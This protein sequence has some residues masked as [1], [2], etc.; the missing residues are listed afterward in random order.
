MHDDRDNYASQSGRGRRAQYPLEIP[1]P[2]WKD[3]AWRVYQTVG[4]NRVILTSAGVSFHILFALVPTLTAFVSLYGLFND[5][6]GV[7]DHISLLY[8]L[9]PPTVLDLIR[10]QLTRLTAE[11]TKS[12]GLSL[13][14]STVIAFWSASSGIRAMF[15]AM[16]VAYGEKESRPLFILYGMALLFTLGSAVAALLV[17][18]VVLVLP[19]ALE[20][21]AGGSGF[22]WAVRVAAYLLMGLVVT[23]GLAA[24][25]RWGPSREQAKWRWITPGALLTVVVMGLT[26]VA[27]S[28]YVANFADADANGSLGAVI[29]LMGWLWVSIT[30]VIVGAEL[31][32]E[33]ERQTARDTTTGAPLPIGSRGAFVADT[34][35]RVWPPDR[36]HLEA[37]NPTPSQRHRSFG[38]AATIMVPML[39]VMVLASL[40]RRR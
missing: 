9:V 3:I 6:A 33:I 14:I 27:I 26:S 29:G 36:H 32:S 24:I 13:V 16:N 4:E 35:G 17:V 22:G 7:L 25:Y 8:G 1:A 5:Q 38:R 37:A 19:P 11:G 30:L 23:L 21:L 28:W 15:Q 18:T 31:N 10:D 12:L 39:I 2:G 34:I 20:L 40:N